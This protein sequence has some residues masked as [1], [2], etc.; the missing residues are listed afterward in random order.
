MHSAVKNDTF[1]MPQSGTIPQA[2]IQ[3]AR[4]DGQERSRVPLKL[5]RGSGDS[6]NHVPG[7]SMLCLICSLHQARK[8]QKQNINSLHWSY[9]TGSIHCIFLVLIVGRERKRG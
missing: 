8:H 6:H 9:V 3:A 2:F 5:A 4:W 7:G 1:S